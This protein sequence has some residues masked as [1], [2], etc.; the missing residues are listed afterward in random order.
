MI[1]KSKKIL[2][3]ATQEIREK[4]KS[5]VYDISYRGEL[6]ILGRNISTLVDQTL[7]S[8]T[9]QV[10]WSPNVA[11]GIYFYRIKSGSYSETKKM[12]ALEGS[13]HGA[14]TPR[15]AVLGAVTGGAHETLPPS[16]GK[17]QSGSGYV[18][19][20]YNVTGF[21][22]PQVANRSIAIPRLSS[23]TTINVYSSCIGAH[24]YT[25][26]VQQ[27]IRGFGAANIVGWR[28]DMTSGQ[29]QTAFGTGQDQVGFSIMRLRI[30][31]DSTQFSINFPSAQAATAMGVTLIATP[32]TPPARMKSNNNVIAGTLNT[33]SYAEFASHLKAF[34]DTMAKHGAPMYALSVQNEPDAS[35]SYESCSWNGAQFLSFMKNNAAA[36][37]TPIFMPESESF[38]H[39]YSDATL[40]D[41]VACANV[42]F[43]GGH[44]YGNTN[45][46]YP[47]ALSKGKELWMTEYLVTDTT[48]SAVLGTGKQINDCMNAQMSAYVWWYIVRYYGPI[49]ET[50]NL[51]MK[52]GYVMSQYARFIRP[53]YHRIKMDA[54]PQS[55][56][57][58]TAYMNGNKMVIVAVNM[59]SSAV[60]QTFVIP[61]ADGA[62]FTP[63][64]T[65]KTKNCAEGY[66][67]AV[68][69]PTFTSVL[70][71]SSVTTFVTEQ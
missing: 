30:P 59:G 1:D 27:I 18:L 2:D 31:P 24:V 17:V 46:T 20:L 61:H 49:S 48:W 34:A 44:L 66:L 60:S 50:G 26:S 54:N 47:L 19:R 36:V 33:G 21:T 69:G 8:G 4:Y 67:I 32:W 63:Y 56:V 35:V 68:S 25:D 28:P 62:V 55:N 10:T 53:G 23:D 65:S 41:S 7:T 57:Y 64:V 15:I 13:G 39:V 38:N 5:N 16:L 45:L 40:N 37:G 12:I 70:D 52:R 51:P 6:D 58:V 14:E 29:I 42:A 71:A 3:G 9:Y 43:M 22:N 11:S